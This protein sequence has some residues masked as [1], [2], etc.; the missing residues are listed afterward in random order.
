MSFVFLRKVKKELSETPLSCF[1]HERKKWFHMCLS[2]PC[3]KHITYMT[4]SAI[5]RVG[6]PDC[7]SPKT[8]NSTLCFAY[9]FYLKAMI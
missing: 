7:F 1:R 4:F 2:N 8:S 5:A 3:D 6:Y 9:Y